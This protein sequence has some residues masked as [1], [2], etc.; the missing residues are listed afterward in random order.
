MN[1]DAALN[2]L[3]EAL[4]LAPNDPDAYVNLGKFYYFQGQIQQAIPLFEKALR[5]DPIGIDA[6]YFLA[7]S[8]IR[9]DMVQQA[10]TNYEAVI[11]HDPHHANAKLNLA[12]ALVSIRDYVTALPYLAEAAALDPDNAELQGHLAEAYLDLGITSSAIDQY[13]KALNL[14]PNRSTWQ[15]N[16]AVLYLRDRQLDLAK[17]H[18]KLSL[19]LEADNPTA[20]HMLQALESDGF[21]KS[22][23]ATAPASY[24]SDLFDQYAGYYNKHVTDTLHYKVPAMLRQAIS[25][26]VTTATKQQNVLD[27]GCGTGLCGIYFSDLAGFL[28]G[29]DLSAEMLAQAKALDAYDGLCRANI[30]ETIPGYGRAVFDIV[31]AADVLV[32]IGDLSLVFAAVKS[33]LRTTG[34]FAFTVEALFTENDFELQSSGRF[35]H[36]EKYILQLA[37]EYN[38][39]VKTFD[40]VVLREQEGSPIDGFLFVLSTI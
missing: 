30:V 14:D 11:K 4:R 32:Y 21:T 19:A 38:F 16:L 34:M 22:E 17:Q 24:I 3:Q 36:S 39:I 40:N 15:H 1:L 33:C 25:K 5:L 20:Q 29:V 23:I 6:H 9:I 31:L 10:I 28:V 2:N 18:F 35:A 7:N 13:N 27:L 8:F 26:H 12:M 37:E